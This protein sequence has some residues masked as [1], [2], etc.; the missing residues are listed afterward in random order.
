EPTAIAAGASADGEAEAPAKAR[1]AVASADQE[2]LPGVAG[3]AAASAE[4]QQKFNAPVPGVRPAFKEA[5]ADGGVAVA[6]VAPEKNSAQE[7]L[8]AA[9]PQATASE[10]MDLS[11]LKVPVPQMLDRRDANAPAADETLV[12]SVGAEVSELS[13]V[14]VPA[15]RPAGDAALA[16]VAE[17]KVVTPDL[18]DRPVVASI[19]EPS[20]AAAEVKTQVALAAPTVE[21]E[22][23]AASP[24]APSVQLAAYAPQGETRTSA[25]VF[26]SAFDTEADAPSKGARPKKQ[27]ADAA[28]RSSVRTEPK[29]TRK[30]ISEWALSTGRVATLS[31]PVKAPR[32]ISSTLRAAPT[33]VYAAGFT[34]NAGTV[35]TARFSGNAVNFMEVKRFSTN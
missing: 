13:F 1:T 14:P 7:A 35:D 31:K 2:A 27:D 20:D 34:S 6:L 17:A 24:A 15:M 4:D 21:A 3:S 33:T 28:S 32:F 26:D 11:A 22:P 25:S 12:A 23:E 8:A 5:P 16:A 19:A 30:I 29:L 10:Y 18:A 9:M